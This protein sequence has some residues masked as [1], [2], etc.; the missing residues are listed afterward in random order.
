[1]AHKSA[2]F[3]VRKRTDRA[4]LIERSCRGSENARRSAVEALRPTFP[5]GKLTDEDVERLASRT[6]VE[7]KEE[8]IAEV[9]STVHRRLEGRY[10]GAYRLQLD[11]EWRF[12]ER[13]ATEHDWTSATPVVAVACVDHTWW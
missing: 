1:M 4:W 11:A 12:P 8:L 13:P 6:S 5:L 9:Y 10:T 7:E 3:V 2:L